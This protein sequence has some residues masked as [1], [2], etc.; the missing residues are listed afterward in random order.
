MTSFRDKD[1]GGLNIA[2]DDAFGMGG[3]ERVGNLNP[4]RQKQFGFK[5][6]PGDAVLQGHPVQK[7]HSDEGATILLADVINGADI[8]VIQRG[9]GLRFTLEAGQ[10]L[11]IL[12]YL[13]RQELQSHEA[14]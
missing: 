12:G 6:T 3:V 11:C 7:L 1:V 13:V 2:V 8:G 10:S 14:V 5:R 4:Q 9:R